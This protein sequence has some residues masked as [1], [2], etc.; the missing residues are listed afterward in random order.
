MVFK[1]LYIYVYKVYIC[2]NFFNAGREIVKIFNFYPVGTF[3]RFASIKFRNQ[4]VIQQ[5]KSFNLFYYNE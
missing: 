4:Q 5:G 2:D 3:W 1:K